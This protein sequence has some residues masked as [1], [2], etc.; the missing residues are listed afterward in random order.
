M[1]THLSWRSRL[2]ARTREPAFLWRMV[3]AILAAGVL[4][5]A[6]ADLTTDAWIFP[7][8]AAD[9]FEE[10][11]DPD[12]GS[13]TTSDWQRLES[14][15]SEGRW[16]AVWWGAPR[17]IVQSWGNW[18]AA[19]LAL[20]TGL[21]WF[22]FAVHASQPTGWKDGRIWGCAVAVALGVLSIWP[23]IFFMLWQ[24]HAWGLAESE[25]PVEGLK[26]FILGVGLREETAKL[27]CVL[28][29]LPWLVRRRDE[30]AALMV[31]GCVGIGFAMEENVN[32]IFGSAGTGTLTRLLMP[33]PLHMAMTG[34][35]GVAAYRACRWPKDWGPQFVLVFGLVV[36]AHGLYDALLSVPFTGDAL[37]E[38]Q[39][40]AAYLVFLGLVYQFFRELR[41]LR[42]RPSAIISLPATFLFCV[43]LVASATFV[44]L[45]A[46]VGFQYAGDMLIGSV[47]AQS[48][49]VYLFLRE[50]PE[51]MVT[52]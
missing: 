35:I 15:A 12:D 2:Q 49:M 10:D 23:T 27:L 41:E 6:A 38:E 48:I 28:P 26:F 32:Y 7:E 47:V 39:S 24:E 22:V 42:S 31:S 30:L 17:V 43:S 29:L 51:S 9:S 13:G 4:A 11:D 14:S 21:S 19:T 34:L 52:V 45:S 18:G 25:Q 44:Y 1:G 40:F 8:N 50:M 36:F 33:A 3:V 37:R 5:G 46:A 20:L 16:A